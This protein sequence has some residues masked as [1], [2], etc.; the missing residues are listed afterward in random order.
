MSYTVK[1]VLKLF[2]CIALLAGCAQIPK[3]AGFPEVKEMV[4]ERVD[5]QLHWNQGTPEDAQVAQTIKDLL[6]AQL[7]METAVQIALLNNRSLQATYE[8]LG[9]TQAAVV[10]AGLLRNPAFFSSA[11]FPNRGPF[12][13]NIEFE[14]VQDFLDL[15][16]LPARKQLAAVQFEQ[17]KLRVSNEVLR[18]VT[19]VQTAYFT[20]L[21]AKQVAAMRR[22]VAEAA[23]I[24]VELAQ[25]MYAAGNISDLEL[26]N[27][28]GLFEQARV[29]WAKAEAEVLAAREPMNSLLGLWGQDIHWTIP[30]RLPEVPSQEMPLEH[31]ENLAIAQR[32][33]LAAVQKE[34][35][36]IGH[37]LAITRK[38]RGITSV[39][40][41]VNS[42]RDTDGTWLLGPNLRLELPIFHQGQPQIARL[43]A[44]LR[45]KEQERDALAVGIR[46]EVR[47][48]RDRLLTTRN[49]I[50]H[51]RDVII[52]LRE[53]IV[54]LTQQQY[55]FMLVGA[56]ELIMAKQNEF[57][58]YQAYLEAIR[59][60]WILRA[61][62]QQAVGGRLTAMTSPGQLPT[63]PTLYT[64]TLLPQEKA[65][66]GM[67]GDQ[68]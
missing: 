14:V 65:N 7:T 19:E 62:L 66:K 10:Q 64:T 32:L 11:R 50:T 21:G 43:E 31:L 20:L 41:A 48:L 12:G 44:Q 5:Y 1:N 61:T 27:Q 38:H 67:T 4:N 52:P 35:E 58:A 54:E 2:L 45:Q 23:E 24:S 8:E 57:D 28:R 40:M 46:A 29:E 22:A 36:T 34:I 15:L 3:T 30:E 17:A 16:M 59:D 53:R 33:D 63:A 25:R 6:R 42:E 26:T 37:A 55:N 60:Y 39:E 68:P 13:Y 51:Y 9:I 47:A 56:F 49:M 18:L